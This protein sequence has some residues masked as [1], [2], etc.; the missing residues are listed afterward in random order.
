MQERHDLFYTQELPRRFAIQFYGPLMN[1]VYS[2][3]I[4]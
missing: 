3:Q 4:W 2:Y 1:K